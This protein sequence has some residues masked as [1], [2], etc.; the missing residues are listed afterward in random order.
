VTGE[1]NVSA[2]ER[3]TDYSQAIG[4]A[5]MP[6]LNELAHQYAGFT[7]SYGWSCPNLSY[8]LQHYA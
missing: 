5:A 4:S 6:Y 8:G 2:T 3:S 7:Q 1:Q